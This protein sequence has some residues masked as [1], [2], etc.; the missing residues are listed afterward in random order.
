LKKNYNFFDIALSK[1][2]FMNFEFINDQSSFIVKSVFIT[3]Y[4]LA[5]SDL[6]VGGLRLL[7]VDNVLRVPAYTHLHFLI[8]S[9]DVI[10]S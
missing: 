1:N 6:P 4:M 10:H 2:N 9:S 5:E 7:E 3:S 8:T